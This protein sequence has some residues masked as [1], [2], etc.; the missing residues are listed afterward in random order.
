MQHPIQSPGTPPLTALKDHSRGTI[1]VIIAT[2]FFSF[3]FILSLS[4]ST[5]PAPVQPQPD[6]FLFPPRPT[7][8]NKIPSDPSPPSIAYLIS[9]SSGDSGRIL[10]LLFATYHPKNHYLLHLD[11]SAPQ[12]DRDRLAVS[13]QSVPVFRAAQNVD[14]IGRADFSYPKGSSPISSTLHGASILLKLSKNWDWFINLNAADYP[15][16]TQDDLL[17]ILSYLP[18]D[19]NF[20]NHTSYIGWRESKKLKPI[21]VDPGLYLS[22]KNPMFYTSQKRELPSAFRLFTG[23]IYEANVQYLG[24]EDCRECDFEAYAVVA[25]ILRVGSAAMLFACSTFFILSRNFIEF[26]ILGV[27]NLPRTLMMYFSNTL[28][29]LSNYFPTILCNSRQFNKTVVNHNLQYVAFDK[30]SK[31]NRFPLNSTEF[32]VM[33]RSGAAFATQFQFDDPVL[34]R[35]DRE[36]L[37]RSPGEVVPGGWC[38]GDPRNSTCSVWGNAD[39]LRPGSGSS[40][41]EKHL[42]DL[43]SSG[44]FRT[45][46]CIVE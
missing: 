15:L 3:V 23:N 43:L 2:S 38:L 11:S 6:P 22:E 5:S 13:V 24:E 37:N 8:P 42:V 25:Y 21:I 32:H 41:L 14:V 16:V 18:K 31:E 26:C 29:S 12:S 45:G 9:G 1:S 10:R 44:K 34:D 46:Q 20:L 33:I 19:L 36:I 40:R 28:S 27:D 30:P 39:F 17:H 35:I 4:F 7:F